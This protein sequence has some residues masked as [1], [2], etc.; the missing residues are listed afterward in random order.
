MLYIK[1]YLND[2]LDT[3]TIVRLNDNSNDRYLQVHI[4]NTPLIFR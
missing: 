4:N 2:E 1:K 3:T